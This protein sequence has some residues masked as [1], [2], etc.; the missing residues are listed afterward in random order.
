MAG[1]SGRTTGLQTSFYYKSGHTALADA[2][3]PAW[4]DFVGNG[5]LVEDDNKI[6]HAVGD[7]E[8]GTEENSGTEA[9]YD[10]QTEYEFP[11]PGSPTPFGLEVQFDDSDTVH[12]TIDEAEAGSACEVAVRVSTGP[13]AQTVRVVQGKLKATKNSYSPTG[14]EK[15]TVPVAVNRI[16]KVRQA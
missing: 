7:V 1:S 6:N 4:S 13:A 10:E 3:N 16:F 11:L 2:N 14:V 8:V 5:K 9:V 12:S 15:M